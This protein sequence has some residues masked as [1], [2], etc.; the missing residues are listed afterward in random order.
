MTMRGKN[1]KS[2]ANLKPA[3][4]GEVRNPQGINRKRPFSD[5]YLIDANAV[6]PEK[7]RRKLNKQFGAPLFEKG[8]TWAE[9]STRALHAKASG[10]DVEAVRELAD[11][12]EGKPPKRLE[13][14]AQPG[15]TEHVL[16]V[17]FVDRSKKPE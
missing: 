7:W 10:G 3:K 13:I 8:M 17:E 15:R 14:T 9:V 6:V 12:L 5:L 11:R 1:P 4:P 2:L 16:R